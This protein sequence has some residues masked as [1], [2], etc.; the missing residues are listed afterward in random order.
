MRSAAEVDEHIAVKRTELHRIRLANLTRFVE[1]V[2]ATGP[3]R[4]AF[5]RRGGCDGVGH[6]RSDMHR[7]L[8]DGLGWRTSSSSDGSQT[9]WRRCCCLPAAEPVRRYRTE[10]CVGTKLRS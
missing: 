3:L 10:R 7:T 5:G 8:V 9:P 4:A 2:A 1:W 6:D